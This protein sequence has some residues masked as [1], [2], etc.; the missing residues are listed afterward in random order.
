MTPQEFVKELGQLKPSIEQLT[1]KGFTSEA[2]KLYQES[3]VA[4][5]HSAEPAIVTQSQFYNE[6][7]RNYDISDIVIT[8]ISFCEQPYKLNDNDIVFAQ[9]ESDPI[10]MKGNTGEIVLLDMA[11][12]S[13]VIA[14]CAAHI[15]GFFKAMLI[16]SKYLYDCFID[17]DLQNNNDYLLSTIAQ[18]ALVAG[19]KKYHQFYHNLLA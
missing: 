4:K 7:I 1:Q 8:T 14:E 15:A 18:S 2:G 6:L 9:D 10:V 17:G 5:K 16:V 11:E 19:G 13:F 3:F 12:T